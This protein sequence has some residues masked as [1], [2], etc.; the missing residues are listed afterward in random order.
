MIFSPIFFLCAIYL[1]GHHFYHFIACSLSVRPFH[2]QIEWTERI[3]VHMK[4][5]IVRKTFRQ[6]EFCLQIMAWVMQ[7]KK[8]WN[9]VNNLLFSH[10]HFA[11]NDELVQLLDL[12]QQHHQKNDMPLLGVYFFFVCLWA[13]TF[14]MESMMATK[15]SNAFV[16]SCHDG[17]MRRFPFSSQ[18]IKMNL[19]TFPGQKFFSSVTT[20]MSTS[21]NR[22]VKRSRTQINRTIWC[23]GECGILRASA[24][25][26]WRTMHGIKSRTC[27]VVYAS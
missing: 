6:S 18:L 22:D 16:A 12:H 17:T 19:I 10:W 3:D 25:K 8:K 26:R 5:T 4:T 9:P 7:R 14:A 24:A 15:N 1:G 23:S 27:N 2:T 13:Q 11:P 20:C 21:R